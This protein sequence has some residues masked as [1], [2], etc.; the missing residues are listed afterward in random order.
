[1]K[2]HYSAPTSETIDIDP[3]S[4]LA[5]SGPHVLEGD[6]DGESQVVNPGD[7]ESSDG[8]AALSKK[9]LGWDEWN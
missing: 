5:G 6:G 3:S 4:I 9:H 2:K 7:E 1:M 8:D